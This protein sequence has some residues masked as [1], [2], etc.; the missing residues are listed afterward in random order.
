MH[1]NL[2]RLES[3]FDHYPNF[4]FLELLVLRFLFP[5]SKSWLTSYAIF[6]CVNLGHFSFDTNWVK[7]YVA[8]NYTYWEDFHSLLSIKDA[9]EWGGIAV[10]IPFQLSLISNW[11]THET[12]LRWSFPYLFVDHKE[13]LSD[14]RHWSA[15]KGEVLMQKQWWVTG[16]PVLPPIEACLCTP[17]LLVL[18]SDCTTYNLR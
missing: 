15:G 7:L 13:S 12:S 14:P 16:R 6:P 1:C 17:E 8:Q 10:T 5:F 9:S 11:L 3:F 4:S 2:S 18:S